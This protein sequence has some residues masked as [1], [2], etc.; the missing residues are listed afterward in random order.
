M[1]AWRLRAEERTRAEEMWRCLGGMGLSSVRM[2]SAMNSAQARLEDAAWENEY[3]M[4]AGV[5]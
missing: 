1:L 2:R 4:T 5:V 3:S